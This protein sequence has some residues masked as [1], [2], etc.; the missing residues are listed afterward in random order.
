M[1][2]TIGAVNFEQ[3]P[4]HYYSCI[5]NF[6]V[7][8]TRLPF[9]FCNPNAT[10]DSR[11]DDLLG[12][13]SI[14][15]KT[16]VL[17]VEGYEV[18]TLG[19]P[20]LGSHENTHGVKSNC[21]RKNSHHNNTGCATSY[22][23]GTGLGAAFDRELWREVGAAIGTEVRGFHNQPNYAMVQGHFVPG[24][25]NVDISL[26]S[27]DPNINLMRD[28]RWGRAQEVPG[29]DPFLTSEF[30]VNLV[31][32][33]Q[34]GSKDG[35]NDTLVSAVSVKHFSLYDFEG[36]I[37]R[38]DEGPLPSGYCDTPAQGCQRWNSDSTPPLADFV[39]YFLEPF[40]QVITR[41]QPTAI[42]C[43]YNAVYGKPTCADN[44]INNKLVRDQW[45]F[46]G[47]FVSDCTALELMQN[48]RW[49]NC[50][51]PLPSDGG[52]CIPE[53]FRGG[54]NYTH[55]VDD[56]IRASLVEGG[57]DLNCGPLYNTNLYSSY[58]K[59]AVS[60]ADIDRAARRIFR[61]MI[62]LGMLDPQQEQKLV[63]DIG[64]NDIDSEIHRHLA[65]RAAQKSLVLL[66]NQNQLLPLAPNT[67]VAFI[68]PHANSSQSML[69]NYFGDNILVNEW[70][71]YMAAL[72]SNHFSKVSYALGAHICDYDYG[73]NPGF[74]NMPCDR[75]EGR[76]LTLI[77]EAIKKAQQ[78]DVVVMFLGSDQTTE[79]EN[80]D[81]NSLDLP[82]N[83]SQQ[84]LIDAITKVNPNIVVVLIH[85]GPMA[86]DHSKVPAILDA[87][88][89]GELGGKAIVDAITG[90]YNPGKSVPNSINSHFPTLLFTSLYLLLFR[91]KASIYKLFVILY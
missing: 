32:G 15:E 53:P 71:P 90:E 63:T 19:L 39:D 16:K 7:N 49:E 79:A 75:A 28:P 37:P 40:R 56:T 21:G 4:S 62:L 5:E 59:G 64:P 45:G 82:G 11:L 33:M 58:L 31:E 51:Y 26:Y 66:K 30:A 3:R 29:E 87:F 42:M 8:G 46:Q 13:L 14:W 77:N 6:A 35:D 34:F 22:P 38:I 48:V 91:R 54:H 55:S 88:F 18:P 44:K 86:F 68:G 43:S 69:S 24:L 36:Y 76:N 57:I 1:L 61:I 41:A 47:F 10:L 81:R 84:A 23:S 67:S 65:L 60:S 72:K 80:F 20:K 50:P 85:G 52:S 12:R 17:R 9:T 78:A 27:L 74:P 70:T 83:G 89:P 73:Q 25:H 2:Q